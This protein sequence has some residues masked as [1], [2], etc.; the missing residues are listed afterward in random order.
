[1]YSSCP[2]NAISYDVVYNDEGKLSNVSW[3]KDDKPPL[4]EKNPLANLPYVVDGDIV[5]CQSNACFSYLGRKLGLWGK[6]VADEVKCEEL[7]CEIM[8]VRNKV[9]GKFGMFLR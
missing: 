4:K 5:I 6:N 7:L 9:V 2:L 1:M 8:D 3:F